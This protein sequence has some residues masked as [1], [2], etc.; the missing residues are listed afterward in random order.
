MLQILIWGVKNGTLMHF[1][2]DAVLSLFFFFSNFFFRYWVKHSAY[3]ITTKF[4]NISILHFKKEMDYR[5]NQNYIEC[6]KLPVNASVRQFT[7]VPI[8]KVVDAPV[9]I[10]SC[11]K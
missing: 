4:V 8:M 9:Q 2:H 5:S 11:N 10:M 6:Y 7:T 1:I 3:W